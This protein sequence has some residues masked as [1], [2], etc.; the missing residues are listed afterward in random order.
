MSLKQIMGS[1]YKEGM[2]VQ[3]IEAFFEGNSKI[4]NLS[5]GG[6]VSKEKFDDIKEKC[7]GLFIIEVALSD[8]DNAL[9]PIM[10][11]KKGELVHADSGDSMAYLFASMSKEEGTELTEVDIQ[12]TSDVINNASMIEAVY[13]IDTSKLMNNIK[14]FDTTEYK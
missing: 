9:I 13:R 8:T 10:I 4:V 3:E 2:T 14:M 7:R 12:T 6:F 1:S 5:N 11:N